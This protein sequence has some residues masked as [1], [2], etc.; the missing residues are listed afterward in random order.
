MDYSIGQLFVLILVSH[1]FDYPQLVI[2]SAI[3]SPSDYSSFKKSLAFSDF[4]FPYVNFRID[5]Y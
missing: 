1:S 2:V 4:V 5:L 3:V